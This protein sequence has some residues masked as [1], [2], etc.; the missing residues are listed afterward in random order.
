M[1]E[2]VKRTATAAAVVPIMFL[3]GSLCARS[4]DSGGPRM[5]VLET[6]VVGTANCQVVEKTLSDGSSGFAFRC[7]DARVDIDLQPDAELMPRLI[8]AAKRVG[9]QGEEG[10]A[11]VVRLWRMYVEMQYRYAKVADEVFPAGGQCLGVSSCDMSYLFLVKKLSPLYY[12]P[13]GLSGPQEL[14]GYECWV[15]AVIVDMAR[16]T[17]ALVAGEPVCGITADL[18]VLPLNSP[19]YKDLLGRSRASIPTVR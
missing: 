7:G 10:A 16:G 8:A 17:F 3:A 18:R 13:E 19:E 9:A 6:M 15:Q 11:V 5:R 4:D 12:F 14:L 1:K 2:V